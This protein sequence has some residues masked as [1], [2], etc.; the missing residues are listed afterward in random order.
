MATPKL[1]DSD[2]DDYESGFEKESDVGDFDDE[3]DFGD[4][5][6]DSFI[7]DGNVFEGCEESGRVVK[8]PDM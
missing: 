2:N 3:S 1:G 4:Q 6:D 8:E 5:S 7:N